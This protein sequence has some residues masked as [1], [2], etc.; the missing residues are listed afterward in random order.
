MSSR[1]AL[2]DRTVGTTWRTIR[3]F[4]FVVLIVAIVYALF[5]AGVAVSTADKCNGQL[6]A[7]KDWNFFP[8][9]WDCVSSL[10]IEN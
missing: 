4:L 9:R 1:P 7:D 5:S 10:P 2:R 8:P 6:H 3:S